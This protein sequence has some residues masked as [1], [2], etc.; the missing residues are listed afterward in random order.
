MEMKEL[1]GLAELMDEE[2]GRMELKYYL[3]GEEDSKKNWL[4]GLLVEIGNRDKM[5]E[6]AQAP[7]LTYSKELA[8][9]MLEKLLRCK[10][11]PLCVEEVVDDLLAQC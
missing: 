3:T 10:I 1:Y 4:Y 7:L 11:T 2:R 8:Q 6:S 5:V 9:T